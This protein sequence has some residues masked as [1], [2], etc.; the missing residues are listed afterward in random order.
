MRQDR[1]PLTVIVLIVV[2]VTGALAM[3]FTLLDFVAFLGVLPPIEAVLAVVFL[4]V[5]AKSIASHPRRSRSR[6][7][8]RLT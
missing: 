1:A 2:I 5:L 4:F 7:P 6:D 8:G 3:T